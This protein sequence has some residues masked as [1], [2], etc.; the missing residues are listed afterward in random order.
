MY[1]KSAAVA[2]IIRERAD[3]RG[4]MVPP[5]SWYCPQERSV[6]SVNRDGKVFQQECGKILNESTVRRLDFKAGWIDD[7]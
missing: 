5:N 4:I 3:H 6:N 2:R 7:E 1:Q